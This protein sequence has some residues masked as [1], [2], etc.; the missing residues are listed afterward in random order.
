MQEARWDV[1]QRC[2]SMTLGVRHFSGCLDPPTG[3]GPSHGASPRAATSRGRQAPAV[4]GSVLIAAAVR[5]KIKKKNR[6]EIP[7]VP[8]ATAGKVPSAGRVPAAQPGSRRD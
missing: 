8:T 1:S 5:V 7:P 4:R 2:L 3:V 6:A